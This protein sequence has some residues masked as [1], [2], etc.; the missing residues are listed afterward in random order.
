MQAMM[1]KN[2]SCEKMSL[3]WL[4]AF[5]ALYLTSLTTTNRLMMRLPPWENFC[6]WVATIYLSLREEV[7]R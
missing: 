5:V 7:V 1:V 3:S 6:G 4:A 2:L